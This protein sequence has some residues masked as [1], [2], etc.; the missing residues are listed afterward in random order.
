MRTTLQKGIA[1][2]AV[3]AAVAFGSAAI[4]GAASNSGSSSSSSGSSG[5]TSSQQSTATPAPP[6]RDPAQVSHGPGETLLTGDTADKVKQAA[7]DEVSGAT[8]IRVETDE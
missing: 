4:S 1:A 5:S 6:P 2:F 7:L 3:L 8:V